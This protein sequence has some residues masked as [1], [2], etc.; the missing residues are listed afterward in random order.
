MNTKKSELCEECQARHLGIC[1]A[2]TSAELDRLSQRAQR[3]A[4]KAGES[5]LDPS[6]TVSRFS[7]ILQGA[8]K[9]T[10]LLPDG[11]QQIVGLQ[12]APDFLGRP[13]LRDSSVSVEAVTESLLCSFPRSVVEEVIAE[14]P[15]LEH[16]LYLQALTEL[17]DARDL[18]RPLGQ[19]L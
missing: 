11:R 13:F 5:L 10:K 17:D 3:R 1:G 15:G 4:V 19:L 2:L 14:S 9:L 18:L 6:T 7:V 8:V 16:R 12:Y